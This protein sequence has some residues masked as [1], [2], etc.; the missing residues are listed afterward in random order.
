MN[1]PYLKPLALAMASALLVSQ[2]AW[3]A[4]EPRLREEVTVSPGRTIGA[5]DEAV[6][7]S[8]ASKVLRHVASARGAIHK[9][10]AERARQELKQAEN[11][12]DII[13]AGLPTTKIKDRIW[14]TKSKLQ[15]ESTQDVLPTLVPIYASLDQLEDIDA[16]KLARAHVD[17][18]KEHLKSGSKPEAR[19]ELEAAD[20]ALF[21][22]EV[23]LPLSATQHFVKLAQADLATNKLEAADKQLQA[24]ED[25][26]VY[27]SGFVSEPLIPIKTNLAQAHAHF[28]AGKTAEARADVQHAI[29]ELQIVIQRAD[30]DTRV[31]AEKL[32]SDAQS[33]EKR[34][35]G[36]GETVGQEI[37]RLWQQSEALADRTM[38]YTAVGWARFHASDGLKRDTIDAKLYVSYA[39]ADANVGHDMK[40][41]MADLKRADDHLAKAQL[42]A[43]GKTGIED[44]LRDARAAVNSILKGQSQPDPGKMANLETQL[45]QMI[46]QL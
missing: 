3:A 28:M 15:Y 20:A 27:L 12:L 44:Y 4:N 18:A 9:K 1:H 30:S 29:S 25:N 37:H 39:D 26:V 46:Q 7:S 23:D 19:Q 31:E 17:K 13:Q 2:T 5:A 35:A 32:L 16:V 14:V 41:A 36:G 34:I 8:A 43:K 11:L 24:A 40:R 38:E 21:Y 45:E 42:A 33:L 6:I 10:E 22:E